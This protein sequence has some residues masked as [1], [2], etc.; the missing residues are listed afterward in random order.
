MSSFLVQHLL[1]RAM[2]LL[3][4]GAPQGLVLGLALLGKQLSR[5]DPNTLGLCSM[6]IFK[7]QQSSS[8]F[9]TGGF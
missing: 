3:L 6:T 7:V 4:S 8:R 2:D 9:K 5:Q 1:V